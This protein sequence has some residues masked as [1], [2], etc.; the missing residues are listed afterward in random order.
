MKNILAKAG[1]YT[2]WKCARGHEKRIRVISGE[3][4]W[5]G[6]GER[7]EP[8]RSRTMRFVPHRILPRC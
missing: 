5:V 7:R 1:Y 2:G 4:E 6:C 8:H 3:F